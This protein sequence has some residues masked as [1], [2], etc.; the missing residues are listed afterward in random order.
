MDIAVLAKMPVSVEEIKEW[1][2]TCPPWGAPIFRVQE[3]KSQLKCVEVFA[4]RSSADEDPTRLSEHPVPSSTTQL[5]S[6]SH[7][8]LEGPVHEGLSDGDV[9][10]W[11]KKLGEE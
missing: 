10:T 9:E 11:F 3:N 6:R 4:S 1:T 2:N 7:T 5:H 8:S